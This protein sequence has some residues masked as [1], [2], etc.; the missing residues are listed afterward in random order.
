MGLNYSVN[1]LV[2]ELTFFL[3]DVGWTDYAVDIFGDSAHVTFPLTNTIAE[4]FIDRNYNDQFGAR[5]ELDWGRGREEYED[6][7]DLIY[8]L[9]SYL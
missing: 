5:I 7:D 2:K 6:M 1:E 4:V 8:E 9:E 3:D